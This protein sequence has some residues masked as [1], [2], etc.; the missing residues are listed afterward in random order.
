M[1][2]WRYGVILDAGSSGTRVHIYRWLNSA[3]ALQ[4]PDP[5]TLQSLP[6]LETNKKWTKKIKPGV[7]TFGERPADV[8]SGTF[9]TTSRPRSRY[10]SKRSSL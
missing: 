8:W 1:G 2:K 7:S 4:N 3:K 6:K 9:T 5:I 10:R